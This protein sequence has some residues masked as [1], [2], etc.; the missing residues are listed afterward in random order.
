MLNPACVHSARGCCSWSSASAPPLQSGNPTRKPGPATGVSTWTRDVPDQPGQGV[1]RGWIGG[2][3]RPGAGADGDHRRGHLSGM[4]LSGPGPAR[5]C[6]A[7]AAGAPVCA[8]TA[9]G[10]CPTATVVA[11]QQRQPGAGKRRR[12]PAQRQ[13]RGRARPPSDGRVRIPALD[14]RFDG[15]AAGGRLDAVEFRTFVDPG[16]KVPVWLAN[17]VATKAPLVTLGRAARSSWR[18]RASRTPARMTCR[19]CFDGIRF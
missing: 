15:D 8:S 9:S 13:R 4:D 14:S 7:P 1:S 12:D 17:L 19:R 2:A 10:R 16:G 6:R 18:S 11:R 5:Q 3:A